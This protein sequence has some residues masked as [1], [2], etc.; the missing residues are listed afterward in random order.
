MKNFDLAIYG[1]LILDQI[2]SLERFPSEGFASR[3]TKISYN[4]GAT[5]NVARAYHYFTGKK[6][7]LY[8]VVGKDVC[9]DKILESIKEYCIPKVKKIKKETSTAVILTNKPRATRTGLVKWGTCSEMKK[10]TEC[11]ASWKH[12]AY[13]DKLLNL[14]KDSLAAMSGIKSVDFTSF[15][16]NDTERER[17]SDCLGEIDYIVSSQE[18]AC[19]FTKSDYIE[20]AAL[21]LGGMCKGFAVLHES[22]GSYVSDGLNCEYVC[23]DH[24]ILD[25]ISVL[26]AGDIFAASFISCFEEKLTMEEIT[27]K[28]HHKTFEL[29]REIND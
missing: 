15:D 28:S 27:I 11:P 29:L 8:S 9:G 26:G 2:L 19:Y 25:N 17:I 23:C 4:P 20:D 13:V 6:P 12:F 3:I 10:F 1:N 14:N 21:V 18:E 24:E 5:A 16:Y 7:L 22:S